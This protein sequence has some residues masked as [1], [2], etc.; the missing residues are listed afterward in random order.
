SAVPGGRSERARR[1]GRKQTTKPPGFQSGPWEVAGAPSRARPPASRGPLAE[2]LDAEVPAAGIDVDANAGITAPVADHL[3]MLQDC[4]GV[5]VTHPNLTAPLIGPGLE[6]SLPR[7][8]E[9][10]VP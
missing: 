10:H 4:L 8:P 3:L 5:L 9:E 2:R 1:H 6:G 7:Q